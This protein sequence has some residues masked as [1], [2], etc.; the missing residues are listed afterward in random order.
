MYAIQNYTN[1]KCELEMAKTRLNLL[2][3]RKEQLYC[4]YFPVTSKIKEIMTD[5]GEKNKDKMAE[6]LYELYDVID[7][8]TGKTLSQE[9][10]DEQN[11][12]N[13]LQ[14]YLDKMDNALKNMN[15]I[16]YELFYEIAYKGVNISKAVENIA[17]KNNK[18]PQTIWKN[19]YRKIKKEIKKILRFSN[20]IQ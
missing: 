17:E 3:D 6:Y 9:I 14:G 16:E 1:T 11:N 13:K 12:I 18:E 8:G 4:K 10:E 5:G 15:G 7:V 20:K 19:H 2:M